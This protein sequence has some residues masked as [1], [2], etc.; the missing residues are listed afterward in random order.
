MQAQ[1]LLTATNRKITLEIKQHYLSIH[2][3]KSEITAQEKLVQSTQ[4][5][6]QSTQMGYGSG[7][8]HKS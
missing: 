1:D 3:G 6:L 2:S 5:K 8:T 7:T 4:S